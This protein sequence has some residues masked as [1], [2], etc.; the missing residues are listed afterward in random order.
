MLNDYFYLQGYGSGN[1]GNVYHSNPGA[2]QQQGMKVNMVQYTGQQP[3][4]GGATAMMGVMHQY[5]ANMINQQNKM[6]SPITPSFSDND[7][8]RLVILFSLK[9]RMHSS[10][11]R[12]VRCSSRLPGGCLPARRV[13]TP[14]GQTNTCEKITFPQLLLRTVK[15]ATPFWSD[16]IV[17]KWARKSRSNL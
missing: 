5:N 8:M 12:T 4:P 14:R 13:Y 10:R 11:M 9:T 16:S 1:Q 2:A 7:A 3:P 6:V 15:M 17:C